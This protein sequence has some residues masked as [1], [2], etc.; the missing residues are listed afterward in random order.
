MEDRYANQQAVLERLIDERARVQQA[1]AECEAWRE[2]KDAAE[3]RA[4]AARAELELSAARIVGLEAMVQRSARETVGLRERLIQAEM[5]LGVLRDARQR[6]MEQRIAEDAAAAE[7]AGA[8]LT[9]LRLEGRIRE[10]EAEGR[11]MSGQLQWMKEECDRK[12]L[13]VV[14]AHDETER[15]RETARAARRQ[16]GVLKDALAK[17]EQLVQAQAARL[18]VVMTSLQHAEAQK[19]A[20]ELGERRAH[21]TVQAVK[22]ERD[23]ATRTRHVLVDSLEAAEALAKDATKKVKQQALHIAQVEQERTQLLMALKRL[24]KS[25]VSELKAA[26]LP[27][28]SS[29]P[30][31]AQV[32]KPMPA[33]ANRR[34]RLKMGDS[35]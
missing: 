2:Q 34:Q 11:T 27:R 14:G 32:G 10:L 30:W 35:E 33:L 28:P 17:A 25:K 23:E 22:A 26:V 20:A 19:A 31:A 24:S 16:Q 7:E 4:A 15:E 5:E 18:A 3:Q 8:A 13:N 6:G 21:E 29:A 12:D 9:V 1:S